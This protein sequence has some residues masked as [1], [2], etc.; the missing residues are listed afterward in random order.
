[1]KKR[2]ILQCNS[3]LTILEV[4]I[5][6]V[7]VDVLAVLLFPIFARSGGHAPR[8]NRSNNLHQCAIALHT[9]CQDY[10]GFLPSSAIV[11]RSK[12]WNKSDFA[13]FAT[14]LGH[15]PV[16]TDTSPSTWTQALYPHM[17]SRDVMFCPDDKADHAAPNSR[18][19]YYWKTA[20]DKAWYGVGCKRP[21]RSETDFIHNADQV[22]FYER[23][24]FHDVRGH[25]WWKKAPGLENGVRINVAYLDTHV[26]SIQITNATS[27]D[28]RHPEL[29][30]N[31]EPMFFNF[32]Q[33]KPKG[34]NNPPPASV[35]AKHTDPL[36]YSDWL[37]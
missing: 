10:D 13:R 37:P 35:P 36:R 23:A 32:D 34:F 6:L 16:P 29:A 25:L 12:N 1:M 11:R 14:R 8:D 31:G 18:V 33:S 20:V 22:V 27:N 3:G 24:G 4:V 19:S 9:Y 5:L 28:P 21:C 17:R 2:S 30:T 15:V 7:I 26:R